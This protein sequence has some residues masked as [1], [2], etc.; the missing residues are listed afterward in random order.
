MNQNVYPAH[1]EDVLAALPIRATRVTMNGNHTTFS[2]PRLR[3]RCAPSAIRSRH[4]GYSS[5]SHRHQ[6]HPFRFIYAAVFRCGH[7]F[8]H[9][10]SRLVAR[11]FDARRWMDT[12]RR[13]ACRWSLGVGD[14]V[15][16]QVE[17]TSGARATSGTRAQFLVL[18]TS[19]HLH[20]WGCVWSDFYTHMRYFAGN[21]RCGTVFQT[22]GPNSGW[23]GRA[24]CVSVPILASLTARRSA[25]R[26]ED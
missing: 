9:H 22:W 16:R 6:A 21:S 1:S 26:Y 4:P 15:Q 11:S 23:S 12:L 17:E 19:H 13:L 3:T 10:D 25:S 20:R 24:D 2:T 7:C 5:D 8:T 14:S 18:G